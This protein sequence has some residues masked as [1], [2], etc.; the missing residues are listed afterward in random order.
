MILRPPVSSDWEAIYLLNSDALVKQYCWLLNL[1]TVEEI[2]NWIVKMNNVFTKD[3]GI[4][5][6]AHKSTE[7]FIGIV[8]VRWNEELEELS[9]FYRIAAEYRRKG[10]GKEAMLA[11]MNLLV[12]KY[13]N[14]PKIIAEIH[15]ENDYSKKLA[16]F[17]GFQFRNR[18]DI[19]ERW[20][21]SAFHINEKK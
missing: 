7:E 10:Y 16:T 6:V 5:I 17:L 3:S 8:G 2:T 13:T 21:W 18:F 14:L 11:L 12:E 19:W 1:D 15:F 4:L 9:V 20:E